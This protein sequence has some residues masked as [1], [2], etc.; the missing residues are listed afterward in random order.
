[1]TLD[2]PSHSANDQQQEK[3]PEDRPRPL[4]KFND[5]SVALALTVTGLVI[6]YLPGALNRSIDWTVEGRTI[7]AIIGILGVCFAL[8]AVARLTGRN[9]LSDW[10]GALLLGGLAVAL[11]LVLHEYHLPAW[12]TIILTILTIVLIF[13]AIFAAV[14]GFAS[15]FEASSSMREDRKAPSGVSAFFLPSGEAEK[16]LSGYERITLVIALLSGLATIAAA[17]EPIINL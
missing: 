15:F 10:G 7:G 12:A 14:S 2:K 9:G 13:V 5:L 11:I 8:F 1:M 16:E 6:V 4:S 17:V 3:A